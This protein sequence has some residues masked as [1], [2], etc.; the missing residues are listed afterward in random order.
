[1]GEALG[2]RVENSRAVGRPGGSAAIAATIG[3]PGGCGELR[4][5]KADAIAM[6]QW[7]SP[8]IGAPIGDFWCG[9]IYSGGKDWTADHK[10]GWR[11]QRRG[12]QP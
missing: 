6:Q 5:R 2:R 12:R 8:L 9:R 1:M 11:R 4:G 10:R 3:A 7:W